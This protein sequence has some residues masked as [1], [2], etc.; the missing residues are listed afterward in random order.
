MSSP[1]HPKIGRNDPCPCGSGK[2]YKHCCLQTQAVS[3]DS[4]RERER[5]ASDELTRAMIRYVRDRFED[6]VLDAWEDF[7]LGH[8][9][10]RFSW[11]ADEQMIFMPYFLFHWNPEFVG[12]RKKALR[13]E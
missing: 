11:T 1:S 9:T 4:I 3:L 13:S 7:H 6:L 8:V 5:E 2:K 10:R 12:R